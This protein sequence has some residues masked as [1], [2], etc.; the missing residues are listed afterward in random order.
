MYLAYLERTS[1]GDYVTGVH[2]I[3]K[4][5]L[6][7]MEISITLHFHFKD[8]PWDAR[9]AIFQPKVINRIKDTIEG[10]F[11]TSL[12]YTTHLFSMPHSIQV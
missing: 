3:E 5:L 11:L 6:R 8:C 2:P 10:F 7:I 4:A 9:K 1:F 12:T